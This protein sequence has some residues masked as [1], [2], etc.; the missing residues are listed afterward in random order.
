MQARLRELPPSWSTEPAEPKLPLY[1]AQQPPLY[2]WLLLPVYWCVKSLGLATRV[3]VLRCITALLASTAI[4]IA[5]FTA[6]RFFSEHFSDERAALGV[7][8]VVA[9]LPQLAID[10]FRVS[11]EGLAIALGNLTVLL[12]IGLWD[13]RP[14]PLR[15]LGVGVILGAALLTKAYFLALLPWAA[16]VLV[17]AILHDR[18]E[19]RAAWVQLVSAVAGCLA[20]AGWYYWRTWILTG[21]LTGEQNDVGAQASHLSWFN[22][23]S[24]A[25]WARIGDFLAISHIWLGNW[26]FLVVRTWMYRSIE[27]VFLLGFLGLVLQV[28]RPRISLPNPKAILLLAMPYALLLLGLCFHAVQSF[29]SASNPGTMGHYLFALVVPEVILLLVGLFRWLPDR[30]RLIAV[31]VLAMVFN[32]LDQFGSAFLLLPYYAGT[33]GHDTRGHLPAL[34]LSQLRQ[35][36]FA[37]IFEGLLANKPAFLTSSELMLMTALCFAAAVALVWIACLIAMPAL[38]TS[39]RESGSA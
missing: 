36:G 29:R 16:F 5:F 3:W 12:V 39:A 28:A 27:I 22:A 19:R 15:G 20:I 2:Y 24:T 25:P 35:G 9:S 8:V 11:N 32:A 14:N 34:G 33:I 18:Q 10:A 30:W 6:R 31:P 37:R 17:R 4:P 13:S 1:E 38:S 23:L 7:A 21:T 26:S